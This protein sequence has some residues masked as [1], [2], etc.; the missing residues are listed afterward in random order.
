MD[1]ALDSIFVSPQVRDLLGVEPEAWIADQY[2][3]SSHVH[4][5]DS[6]RVWD[7][8]MSA[9]TDDVPLSHEYR[10]VHEDGTVKWVLELARPIH[11]EHGDP[12]VIQGVI[13]DITA[14][15]E[16]EEWQAARNERLGSIIETQ[17]EI[18]ATELDVDAVMRTICER[19]QELT[20]AEAATILILEGDD[21]VLRVGTRVPRRQDRIPRAARGHPTRLDAPARPV[22][23]PGRRADGP[24]SG[25]P[26]RRRWGCARASPCSST[27]ARR[28]SVSSIVVSRT[29]D[30]FTQEDVDT[31]K[32]LSTALS[33]AISHAAEFESKLQQVEALARFETIYEGAAIGITLVSPEGG[34]LDAN[35]AFE[36]MFGY[37]V[38]E[39][40][41]EVLPNGRRPADLARKDELFREMMA[42]T[43][44]T[45]EQE[46]RFT[47]KDGQLVWGHVAAALQRDDGGQP[48][49]RDHDDRE[50][51]GT[52]GGRAEARV[53]RLPRRAHGLTNRHGS[54]RCSRRRSREPAGSGLRSAVITWISTTSS[55]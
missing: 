22:R 13:F 12:W 42:G 15:K 40:R 16:A 26:W 27:R 37:T 32:R 4:P 44:D 23:D 20:H 30:A 52:E 55:S 19:T 1:E 43:R 7:E 18:A 51:H 9:Y 2:C 10:M 31:L 36:R 24:A 53:P 49:V 3:W 38:E 46:R 11:D 17:R 35:P 50:H 34:F 41:S 25:P 47:R 21:L 39:L 48:A 8:Y 14:R 45:Y 54:S 5:D 6:V 29:P 28:R 33:S